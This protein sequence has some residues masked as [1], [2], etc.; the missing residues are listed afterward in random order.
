KVRQ[1]PIVPVATRV[2][3]MR[4][5]GKPVALPG[6]RGPRDPQTPE[7]TDV[8]GRFEEGLRRRVLSRVQHLARQRGVGSDVV[9]RRHEDVTGVPPDVDV[10]GAFPVWQAVQ[11][12]VALEEAA[13]LEA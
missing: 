12:E 5:V 3:M 7:L 4:P 10:F 13:M 9:P 11:G 2:V 6:I 8:F 1:M